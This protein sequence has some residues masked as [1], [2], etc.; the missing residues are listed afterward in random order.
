MRERLVPALAVALAVA[1][2]CATPAFH[3]YYE[4]GMF[5]EAARAYEADPSLSRSP[6]ALY[7]AAQVHAYPGTS[8]YDPDRAREELQRLVERFPGSSYEP[9]ARRLLSLLREMAGLRAE[10][11]EREASL[12]TLEGR[13][14]R[15]EEERA[16]REEELDTLRLRARALEE[17]LERTRLELERL[18]AIDL[19]RRP[20]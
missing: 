1:T 14:R 4:S 8:A 18:K 5:E 2:A 17:E 3:R 12:R 13:V 6:R 19:R 10:L 11:T 9:Q 15:L 20:G 16:G 7:R